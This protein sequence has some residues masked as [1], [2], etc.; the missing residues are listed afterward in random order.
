KNV[1]G[2]WILESCR[3]EWKQR[4]LDVNYETLLVEVKT[5]DG[6]AGLI[7]PDDDRFFNPPSMLEVIAEQLAEN[8]Q[9]INNE[10]SMVAKVILD[11]LAFRY[12][13]VLRTIE[14]LT[15][16]QIK[17]VHIVGGGSQNDYLNQATA[18][19]IGL[20][21][22]AGPT[23]ATATGNVLVQ[24]IAA[25]RLVLRSRPAGPRTRTPQPLACCT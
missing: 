19:A 5:L 2:L 17:G 4:G 7:F 13:S 6:Y 23:E 16:Q 3:R 25:G 11:S 14:S 15:N 21:V 22:L 20:T 8:D 18:T 10:P 9:R 12:A 1:M 24:A